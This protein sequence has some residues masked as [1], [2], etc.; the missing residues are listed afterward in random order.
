MVQQEY[1][2]LFTPYHVNFANNE[3]LLDPTLN[4]TR[5]KHCPSSSPSLL[6][7]S[8]F[9]HE[10]NHHHEPRAITLLVDFHTTN[11]DFGHFLSFIISHLTTLSA[12]NP[13]TIL[14]TPTHAICCCV[15]SATGH[16][17]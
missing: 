5:L 17:Y 2:W 10:C 15:S 6:H 1:D 7:Y 4:S 12:P 9:L 13:N 14:N 16:S 11:V 3:Y 8:T